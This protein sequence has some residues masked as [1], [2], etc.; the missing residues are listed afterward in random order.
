MKTSFLDDSKGR[1]LYQYTRNRARGQEILFSVTLIPM[2]FLLIDTS[3]SFFCLSAYDEDKKIKKVIIEQ[4][5]AHCAVT[6]VEKFLIDLE[7]KITDLTAIGIGLGPGSFTGVRLS[8]ILA[9]GFFY[10]QGIPIVSFS[11]LSLYS[12]IDEGTFYVVRHAFLKG[13]YLQKGIK[14]KEIIEWESPRMIATDKLSN[15]SLHPLISPDTETLA[16]RFPEQ[17]WEKQ[18]P[19]LDFVA[20][21]VQEKIR[22][23]DF[24]SPPISPYYLRELS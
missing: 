10:T 15:Y 7:K 20:K 5:K 13:L 19:N 17:L 8:A 14:Q 3:T 2:F 6:E 18:N 1:K 22:R 12:P 16:K 21:E 9:E 24:L 23:K 11:S 4:G